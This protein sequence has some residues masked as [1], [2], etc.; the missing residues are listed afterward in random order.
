MHIPVA[1][2]ALQAD[3]MPCIESV[4]VVHVERC[5]QLADAFNGSSMLSC[6]CPKEKLS[7]R[8]YA[9]NF[10]MTRASFPSSA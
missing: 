4:Q 3:V 2:C 8:V 9:Q 6:K 7:A 10:M 1:A 5:C